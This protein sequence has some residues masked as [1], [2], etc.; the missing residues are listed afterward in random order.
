MW[1]DL[2]VCKGPVINYLPADVVDAINLSLQVKDIIED[3]EW[4]L[5]SL[6]EWVPNHII[7]K[8]M[9][10]PL[11]ILSTIDNTLIWGRRLLGDALLALA[12]FTSLRMLVCL[13]VK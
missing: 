12:S 10:V 2:W 4:S 3:G 11:P 6:L 5:S 8:I 9:S 13:R 7:S 1:K